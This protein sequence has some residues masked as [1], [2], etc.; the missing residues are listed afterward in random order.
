M[1]GMPKKEVCGFPCFTQ[2][3]QKPAKRLCAELEIYCKSRV[4]FFTLRNY[5]YNS[6]SFYISGGDIIS[7]GKIDSIAF[8]A[9]TATCKASSK[10][11]SG[12]I[13]CFT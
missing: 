4:G 12:K 9:A 8:N 6:L 1:S 13:P 5:V 2:G 11:F 3:F 10:Y 7:T